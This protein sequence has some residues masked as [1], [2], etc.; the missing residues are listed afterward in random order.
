MLIILDHD[1]S[2]AAD[3]TKGNRSVA[4]LSI[5]WM[6]ELKWLSPI[7]WCGIIF[8]F[9]FRLIKLQ[10]IH[11]TLPLKCFQTKP[12][13]RIM[14]IVWKCAPLT[15]WTAIDNQTI[16]LWSLLLL[17]VPSQSFAIVWW[18]LCLQAFLETDISQIVRVLFFCWL[19]VL[20][21]KGCLGAQMTHASFSSDMGFIYTNWSIRKRCFAFAN[22]HTLH[23][24][25]HS[26]I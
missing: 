11:T 6:H 24:N 2:S 16:A 20:K 7:L 8:R 4:D 18:S 12:I 5:F 9:Y 21:E 14:Q 3:E 22:F 10:K 17:W 23:T 13:K 25:R 19:L 1:A 26:H 15:V